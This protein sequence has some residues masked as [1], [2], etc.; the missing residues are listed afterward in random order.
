MTWQKIF[1]FLISF[2]I[3]CSTDFCSTYFC[4]TF[5][6]KLVWTGRHHVL[7]SST[8]FVLPWPFCTYTLGYTT[9]LFLMFLFHNLFALTFGG[10]HHYL[11]HWFFSHQI[12]F[13]KFYYIMIFLHLHLC[14]GILTTFLCHSFLFSHILF[15]SVLFPQFC[16]TMTFLHLNV[17]RY[18]D[19]FLCHFLLH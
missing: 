2:L 1:L 13:Q 7:F 19:H 4:S 8:H 10:L 11:F 16:S 18:F 12:N 9:N 6:S 5:S 14:E 17:W 3:F 15:H